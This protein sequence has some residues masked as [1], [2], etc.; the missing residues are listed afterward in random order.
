VSELYFL[1]F[2]EELGQEPYGDELVADSVEELLSGFE[3]LAEALTKAQERADRLGAGRTET[4][5]DR[6]RRQ[7]AAAATEREQAG[8]SISARRERRGA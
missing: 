5:L 2:E 3:E 1:L 6:L 7:A 8:A 4:D